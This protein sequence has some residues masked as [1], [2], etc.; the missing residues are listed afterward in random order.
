MSG[1]VRAR[2]EKRLATKMVY[3]VL[4]RS[5]YACAGSAAALVTTQ[6]CFHLH[7]YEKEKFRISKGGPGPPL[8]PPLHVDICMHACIREAR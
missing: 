1:V 6:I 5:T 8:D 3:T 2:A 4:P 7:I